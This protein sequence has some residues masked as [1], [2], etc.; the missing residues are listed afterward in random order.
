MSACDPAVLRVC[1][2]CRRHVS[3]GE[4]LAHMAAVGASEEESALIHLDPDLLPLADLPDEVKT[5][6]GT[7]NN[8]KPGDL[9]QTPTPPCLSGA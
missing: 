7:R 8:R 4:M 5:E 1:E 2:P 9:A 6:R 3:P